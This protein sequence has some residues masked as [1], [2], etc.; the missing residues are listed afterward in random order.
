MK[1]LRIMVL[2]LMVSGMV[3][4]QGQRQRHGQRRPPVLQ[5]VSN[6]DVVKSVYPAAVK[7]DKVNEYW[8]KVLDSKNKVLGYAL[9]SAEYCLDVKGYQNTT[10]VMIVTDKKYIIQ[11]VALLSNWESPDYVNRLVTRGFFDSWVGKP[12]KVANTVQADGYTGATLTA[13]A[14]SKNVAFL[15]ENGAK[16]LPKRG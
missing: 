11:K 14:V 13:N 12:V 15:V 1:V 9:S 6:A 8:Y 5:E 16:K 4:G 3:M 10:P 7:V 2:I